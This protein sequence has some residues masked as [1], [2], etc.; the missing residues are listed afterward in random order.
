MNNMK[1][2]QSVRYDRVSL[3]FHWVT[4]VAVIAAFILGPEHFGRL[5]KDGL[6]PA[7]RWDIVWHESLGML[8]LALTVLRLLW[9]AIRRK[10]PQF[11]YAA[12]M[13]KLAR[14]VHG[15]LWLLLLIVPVTALMT[16]GSEGFPMTLLGGVK[17]MPLSFLAGSS[18][19]E[20][21]DWGDL[22]G[23]LANVILWLAGLHAI[24]AIFHHVVLKDGV[25]LSMS[26]RNRD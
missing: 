7:T 18:F 20:M 12:W 6:D 8:V 13:K 16:L 21:V 10:P 17:L 15:M 2:Q 19:G 3:I 26:L 9:V 23:L 5:M 11:D 1:V 22:H 14:A 25:L 24:A 4:A